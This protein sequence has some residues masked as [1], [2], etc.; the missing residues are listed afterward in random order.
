MLVP[1]IITMRAT[2][3]DEDRAKHGNHAAFS[4][5]ALKLLDEYDDI[6]G[7]RADE[8]GV[9]YHLTLTVDDV[10]GCHCR[11]Y[12]ERTGK[13][14]KVCPLYNPDDPEGILEDIVGDPDD[15]ANDDKSTKVIPAVKG[16]ED[17]AEKCPKCGQTDEGQQGEYPC[18]ECGL[19]TLHGDPQP[20]EGNVGCGL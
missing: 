10:K 11:S 18:S 16:G 9:N 17:D 15:P 1:G 7:R 13:H 8:K 14:A 6:M 2:I 5:A 4:R 19:P 20:P 3:T 12:H